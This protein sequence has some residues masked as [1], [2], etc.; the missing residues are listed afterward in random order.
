MQ[1]LKSPTHEQLIQAHTDIVSVDENV[2]IVVDKIGHVVWVNIAGA[3]VLRVH[4]ARNV[5]IKD[6][7]N[8]KP[9][10]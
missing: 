6:E 3:C 8:K 4:G 7:R 2:E 10:N 1:S 9:A 5:V